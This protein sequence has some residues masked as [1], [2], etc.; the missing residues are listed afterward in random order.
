MRFRITP[1]RMLMFN[2]T[3]F[4]I[5]TGWWILFFIAFGMLIPIMVIAD[6]VSGKFLNI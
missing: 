6:A 1:F 4:L 5:F 2:L 3:L